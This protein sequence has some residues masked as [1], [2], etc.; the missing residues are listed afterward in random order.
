MGSD[1]NQCDG[2]RRGLPKDGQ[3]SHINPEQT[4]DV[5]G[6]TANR[7]DTDDDRKPLTDKQLGDSDEKDVHK[8][9]HGE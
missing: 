1:I 7:Y 9:H 2:C 8:I 5:I 4:F 6:C 3:G